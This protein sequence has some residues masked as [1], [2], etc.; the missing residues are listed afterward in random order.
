MSTTVQVWALGIILVLLIALPFMLALKKNAAGAGVVAGAC[1][2]A[3]IL[4]FIPQVQSLSFGLLRAEMRQRIDEADATLAQLRNFAADLAR[5]SVMSVEEQG[6]VGGPSFMTF[7]KIQA[8]LRRQLQAL[9]VSDTETKEILSP[10]NPRILFAFREEIQ[11]IALRGRE[12]TSNQ[13]NLIE[14]TSMA[15]SE[16]AVEKLRDCLKAA[17]ISSPELDELLN[18]M[19]EYQR[20]G[21]VARWDAKKDG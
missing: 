14:C 15:S 2:L 20:T 1:G 3:A 11:D 21:H 10:L 4:V 6:T 13:D 7:Y 8:D 19:A 17:S 5:V 16:S 18:E 12:R 9:Q